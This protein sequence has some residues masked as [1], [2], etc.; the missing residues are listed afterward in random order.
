MGGGRPP[1]L[2]QNMDLPGFLDGF[3]TLLRL[4]DPGTGLELL[5]PSFAGLIG[6]H[7]LN[8]RGLAVC[9]N[10][11]SQ[12]RC[13]PNGLP[14]AFVV[15]STLERASLE[16]AADHLRRVPHASGQNYLLGGPNGLLDLECSA[17]GAVRQGEGAAHL[18]HTNHPLA[19]ADLRAEVAGWDADRAR[20]DR[21]HALTFTRLERLQRGVGRAPLTVARV[22]TLLREVAHP[23]A[24]PA[25]V[26]T[27]SSAV[28]EPA[29]RRAHVAP[30]PAGTPYHE[31]ALV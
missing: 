9:V 26:I 1:R 29:A 3:Q 19:S 10:T 2:G 13:S 28:F 12:L 15:R 16:D 27:F 17:S 6:L 24:G 30:G 23:L 25:D 21:E 11:L 8:N 20:A 22:K 18:C 7:G 31:L 14:V 4:R 5:V